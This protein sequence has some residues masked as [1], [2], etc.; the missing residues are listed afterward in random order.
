MVTNLTLTLLKCSP[1]PLQ[2][3]LHSLSLKVINV[4][5]V[6]VFLQMYVYSI[7]FDDYFKA[8]SIDHI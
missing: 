8:V 1:D 5:N 7:V 2:S 4:I 3:L 6:H